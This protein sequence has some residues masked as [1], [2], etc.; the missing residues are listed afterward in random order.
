LS[1]FAFW[2]AIEVGLVYGFVALGVFLS[3]RVLSFPDLTVDGSFPLGAMVVAAL[4]IGG[5]PFWGNPWVATLVAFFAGSIAGLVTAALNVVF[6]ILHLL[7]SILTM[8][9]LYS[10]NLRVGG[11]RPNLSIRN[12]DSVADIM[13]GID[14][15]ANFVEPVLLL[16]LLAIA[17]ALLTW[18]LTSDFGLG[19]RATGLNPKMARAQGVKTNLNIYAG[20]ALSNGLVAVGGGL[21]AQT[22][23]FADAT[24][25]VGT[26]VFGLAAVIVGETLNRFRIMWV[27][28]VFCILGSVIYRLARQVALEWDGVCVGSVCIEIRASDLNLITAVII[29]LALVLPQIRRWQRRTA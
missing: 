16:V 11:G 25:G 2:S 23:G 24:S 1:A 28:L 27:I 21:F 8:Y 14:M 15:P 20:M 9:A 29:V 26:I 19:M 7:A 10:I 5:D 13:E 12:L 4:L 22:S 18:F 17:V 3:F 6:K